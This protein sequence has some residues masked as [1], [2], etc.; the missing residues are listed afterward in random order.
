MMLSNS[1]NTTMIAKPFNKSPEKLLVIEN[2]VEI[3]NLKIN[4]NDLFK[5]E[6][7]DVFKNQT[8][9]LMVNLCDI[10]LD[11]LKELPSVMEIF[12]EFFGQLSAIDLDKYSANVKSFVQS[13]Q[14]KF[15]HM[16]NDKRYLLLREKA[17]K[18]KALRLYEPR[19]EQM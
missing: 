3:E 1:K 4:L 14:L 9:F 13:V 19:I 16:K 7:D 2:Q 10:F 8:M 18:P 6:I 5:N 12:N 15:N 11:N 17:K